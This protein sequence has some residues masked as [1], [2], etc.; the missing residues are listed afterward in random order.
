MRGAVGSRTPEVD[1]GRSRPVEHV[2]HGT[3]QRL[4]A[5]TPMTNVVF[6]VEPSTSDNG[7]FVPSMTILPSGP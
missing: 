1:S 4:G 6:S 3:P 2:Q 7:Y 5:A